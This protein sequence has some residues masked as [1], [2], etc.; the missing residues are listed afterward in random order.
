MVSW[1][2]GSSHQASSN[3]PSHGWD[4]FPRWLGPTPEKH[5]GHSVPLIFF[6]PQSVTAAVSFTFYI[7][8]LHL[9]CFPLPA[10]PSQQEWQSPPSWLS[11]AACGLSF[12]PHQTFHIRVSALLLPFDFSNAVLIIFCWKLFS[13]LTEEKIKKFP[14]LLVYL[15]YRGLGSTRLLSY[16]YVIYFDL[17][18]PTPT[19]W[20]PYPS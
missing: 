1:S 3:V 16:K 4:Q 18:S 19:S 11:A 13:V 17:V 6:V 5:F 20:R 8:S 7:L 15:L 10:L 14:L 2:H 12:P 9:F